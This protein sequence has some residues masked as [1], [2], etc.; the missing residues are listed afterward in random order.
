MNVTRIVAAF[1]AVSFAA[2]STMAAPA[3][4]PATTAPATTVAPATATA[5][6]SDVFLSQGTIEYG[7]SAGFSS[8]NID[9]RTSG[10]GGNVRLLKGAAEADYFLLDNLSVGL[11]G[12]FDWLRME[13]QSI[14]NAVGNATLVYGELVVRYHFPLC[15]NHVIP[16][17]GVSGGAGYAMY[18]GRTGPLNT[19]G[20]GTM[21][22]WGLQAGFLVP[23]NANVSLDTCV[24]YENYQLPGG[25]HTDLDGMQVL[26]GFKM[27]L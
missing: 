22:D 19:Y 11:A 3:A 13:E 27:K 20:D 24:K 8:Y 12:D 25:W 21:T 14:D 5:A 18:S 2:G 17:V 26:M 9:Q 10:A 15:N 4:A 1:V 6:D 7:G 16:Y 23:L